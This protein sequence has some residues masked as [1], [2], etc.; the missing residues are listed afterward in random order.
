MIIYPGKL[1]IRTIILVIF[2]SSALFAQEIPKEGLKSITPSEMKEHVIYLASDKMK[3][4][5]TP[6]PELDSC[7]A[8]IAGEFAS[9]GLIPVAPV[10]QEDAP[11]MQEGYY[12]TFNMLRNRL[13]QPNSLIVTVNGAES[14][15]EI[16]DDF[17]PLNATANR[18]ITAPL[19]FAG[20]GITAPEYEYDDYGEI[21]TKGKIVLVFTGEPQEKDSTSVFNGTR[22]TTYSRPQ[23]KIENAMDH[24]AIGL[25]LVRNPNKRFRRPPNSWPSLMKRSSKNNTYLNVEKR[26]ENK[27]V[28][29]Q[30]GKNLCDFLFEQSEKTAENIHQLIDST[31]TPQSFAITN[32]TVTMETTLEADRYP[33]H[34]VVGLWEGSD[35]VLKNE[36][37]VIGAHYDHVGVRNDTV[38]FNG[39]D[40][41]ASG[42]AGVMEVAE[43]FTKSPVR[44]KRSILF[45]A[46]AGEEKGLLGSRFYTD[47]PLFPIVNTAAMLNM[48]MISRND[49]NEVAIVGAK[50]S[51][52]LKEINEEA[53]IL[54]GMDLDYSQDGFFRQSDHYPFYSKDIPVLFYFAKPNPDLHKA[55]DDVEKIIPEK[56]AA[57]GKLVFSTAWMIANRDQ[58]PDF[59]EVK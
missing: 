13:S 53:N 10:M 21:E 27:I 1:L 51:S 3:G 56:M 47:N 59:T 7:A 5:N 46:F 58:R 45:M 31:S 14:S 25:I 40:D 26:A 9:Y 18:N 35:P 42:T 8:Y 33:V 50:T 2:C 49:T 4:R 38:I 23:T 48:D 28:C 37:I 52:D 22:S 43:A 39:A 55:T 36:Y 57:I 34:N 44:P 17:V 20:Y 54:I 11:V 12:Q 19:V 15:F 29:M 30:I 16:R 32:S 24:G 6:S 41:N